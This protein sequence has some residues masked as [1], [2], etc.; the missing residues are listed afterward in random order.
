LWIVAVIAFLALITLSN[1]VARDSQPGLTGKERTEFVEASTKT[2]LAAS[3]KNPENKDVS[4]ETMMQYCR[5]FA[6]GMADALSLKEIRE[7]GSQKAQDSAALKANIQARFKD[8]IECCSK[9]LST[10]T[11]A[12]RPYSPLLAKFMHAAAS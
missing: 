1:K 10:E 7:A 9:T 3:E 2:C 5:C 12:H 11:S 6:N 8:L 4:K